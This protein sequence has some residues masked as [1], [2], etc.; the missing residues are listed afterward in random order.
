MNTHILPEVQVFAPFQP[1]PPPVGV[2]DSCE[3]Y[4]DDFFWS[5]ETYIGPK[6]VAGQE[7][8]VG[9]RGR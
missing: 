8:R 5:L 7:P 4:T 3:P 6:Q 9:M 1:E 2:S